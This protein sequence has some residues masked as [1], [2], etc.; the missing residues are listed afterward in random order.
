MTNRILNLKHSK[1]D[2]RNYDLKNYVPKKGGKLTFSF[3]FG[4]LNQNQT[5]DFP[6]SPL[7]QKDTGHCCG[8]GGADFGITSPIND[9]WD[10]DWGHRIYYMCKVRDG[11]PT[12]EDGSSVLT[13]AKVLQKDL[14]RI[15]NYA[16]AHSTE[17]I[18]YWLKYKGPIVIGVQWTEGMMTP[19]SDNFIRPTG[20]IVGGHCTIFRQIWK[21]P[22]GLAYGIQNSWGNEWG[23]NG[24]AFILASDFNVLLQAQGE[25]MAAVEKPL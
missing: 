6:S 16:F 12:A 1:I 14:K 21:S 4:F 2:L 17:V 13:L 15:N 5:W 8:F 19:N 3:N 25:A 23:V 11:E 22:Y 9:L 10:N 18:N 7:D 24:L 20:Q